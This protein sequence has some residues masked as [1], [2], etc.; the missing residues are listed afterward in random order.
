MENWGTFGIDHC[1]SMSG[2]F[3][4]TGPAFPIASAVRF[5]RLGFRSIFDF[6]Y[7]AANGTNWFHSFNCFF[8]G[9]KTRDFETFAVK[10]FNAIPLPLLAEWL[11]ILSPMHNSCMPALTDNRFF[12]M[13]RHTSSAT[14]GQA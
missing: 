8:K 14:C 2:A 5:W 3:F 11:I 6:S 4:I 1:W 10:A 13:R 12:P 7:G 9:T